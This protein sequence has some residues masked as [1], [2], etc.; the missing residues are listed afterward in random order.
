[1]DCQGRNGFQKELNTSP[2]NRI[3]I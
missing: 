2:K 1:V 3:W